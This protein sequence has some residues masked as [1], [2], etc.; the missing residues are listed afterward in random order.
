MCV[1]QIRCDVQNIDVMILAGFCRNCLSKWYHAG[2]VRLGLTVSY[3]EACERVYGM[4]YSEWKK[5]HQAKASEEQLRRL[6]E[7]K[8]GHAKHESV[9][10]VNQ[11]PRMLS[12]VCCAPVDPAMIPDK[13]SLAHSLVQPAQC[14]AVRVGVLTVSDRASAGL[15]AD[16]AGPE[17]CR[18][19]EEFARGAGRNSWSLQFEAKSVVPD[20][21]TSIIRKLEEWSCGKPPMCN[22]LLTTGGTGI[23]PRDVTP[24]ATHS[25]LDRPTP[26][27]CELLMRESL[28]I[29]PLA[30]LSRAAAGV[31][32][33][34]FIVNL[35]GRPKAIR[36]NL[37]VLMPLLA[38]ALLELEGY[39]S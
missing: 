29:E 33:S 30:A 20:D 15:Y 35:P 13:P 7:T 9:A 5:T 14:V 27:I 39:V 12:D 31:R 11:P 19:L 24:E 8:T 22:L 25:V 38:H 28:R 17:V 1:A 37:S 2:L 3:E 21:Q 6:E 10:P 34:T 16:L 32:G 26:G 23:A 18:C 4:P 36:E